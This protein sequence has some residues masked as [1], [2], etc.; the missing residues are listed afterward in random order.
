MKRYILLHDNIS[1]DWDDYYKYGAVLYDCVEKTVFSTSYG[2]GTDLEYR[3]ETISLKEALSMGVVTE[4]E[5]KQY[6]VKAFGLS[7]E[8]ID[9]CGLACSFTR[10]TPMNIPVTIVRGRKGK[11]K[12]G[13]L[14]Y[15]ERHRNRYGWGQYH[16][17]YDEYAFILL[18][19]TNDV[20]KVNSFDYLKVD[21]DYIT[22]YNEVLPNEIVK[23]IELSRL[24]WLYAYKMSYSSCDKDNLRYRIDEFSRLAKSLYKADE[25]VANRIAEYELE[26]DRIA[27]EKR[28]ALKQEVMPQLIDWV[29]TNTDKKGEDVEKLALHIFNKRY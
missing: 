10:Q 1:F 7:F 19:G 17:V 13:R 9:L 16:D 25:D 12:R 4:N 23:V 11:G 15:G 14:I 6:I 28:E 18:E 26:C 21:E 2:H 20:I 5:I 29:L 8:K 3:N 27:N 22:Q 24:S